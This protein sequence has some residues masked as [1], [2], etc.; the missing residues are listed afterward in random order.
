M[1]GGRYYA[2][3]GIGKRVGL[4]KELRFLVGGDLAAMKAEFKVDQHLTCG[5]VI[6]VIKELQD[7]TFLP[8]I[9]TD[10]ALWN[11]GLFGISLRGL[12][13]FEIFRVHDW[14]PF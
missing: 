13:H 7:H 8:W 14:P 4:K 10:K 1:I 5:P 6:G 12:F 2:P 3:T 11:F 9:D